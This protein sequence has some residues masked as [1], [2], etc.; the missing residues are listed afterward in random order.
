MPSAAGA[1]GRNVAR[2][3]QAYS[4][5][6]QKDGSVKTMSDTECRA[7]SA[8]VQDSAIGNREESSSPVPVANPS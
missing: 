4:F 8:E 5:L 1:G 2:R 6:S 7:R 3:P